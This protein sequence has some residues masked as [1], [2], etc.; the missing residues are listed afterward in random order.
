MKFARKEK[1]ATLADIPRRWDATPGKKLPDFHYGPVSPSRLVSAGVAFLAVI[2]IAAVI[3][4][5]QSGAL[6]PA[7]AV[8]AP[9]TAPLK[10]DHQ[11]ITASLDSARTLMKQSEWVKA[12]TVLRVATARFPEEQEVRIALAE[13]LLA[14]DKTRESYD[15]YE[16]ALAI[17]PR[18]AKLEFAAGQVANKAG[19]VDRAE[20]HF[21]MAQAADRSNAA[22]PLMLGMVQRKRGNVEAS[23][24]SMLRAANMDPDNA[25]AWGTLADIALNENKVDICLQ[26]IEKARKLQPESKDWRLIEA[27]ARKRKGEAN[28]ALMLLVPLDPSQRREP[29]VVRL[30]AECYGMLGRQ[31]E[32]AAAV[33]DASRADPT[34]AELAYE[35]ATWLE[36]SGN[37]AEAMMYAKQA[38][39][40]GHKDAVKLVKRL[41]Q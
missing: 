5:W 13:T 17:G 39:G 2:M 15:Q 18:E 11:A 34:N 20:E 22:Y 33:V 19:L 10:P 4:L 14:M 31:T 35:A 6:A 21:G 25:Y 28:E 12:E 29:Q 24:A 38:E 3:L 40:L 30:I 16:K 41:A 23:K 37:K 7:D 9:E 36:R 1:P 32:A 27:R 26:H 8:A